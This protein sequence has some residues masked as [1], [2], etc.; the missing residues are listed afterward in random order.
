M[1]KICI[2]LVLIG[3]V[4]TVGVTSFKV[5]TDIARAEIIQEIKVD[6]VDEVDK[7]IVTLEINGQYYDYEY[8]YKEGFKT[9]QDRIDNGE[10]VSNWAEVIK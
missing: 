8:E 1:K 7:G 10:D 4:V 3:L 2:V 9:V 5:A 6:G